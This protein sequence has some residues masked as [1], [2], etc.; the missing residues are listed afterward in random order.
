LDSFDEIDISESM[1]L[2]EEIMCKHSIHDEEIKSN[3]VFLGACNP[4]RTMTKKLK[5]VDWYII[6]KVIEKGKIQ[7]ILQLLY[8]LIY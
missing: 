5:K 3:L 2:I 7:Y 6:I 4:Y 8:H 1:R